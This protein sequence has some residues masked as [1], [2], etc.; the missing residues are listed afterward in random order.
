MTNSNIVKKR[1]EFEGKNIT[2]IN[3]LLHESGRFVGFD[4]FTATYGVKLNFV[5]LYSLKHCLP[6]PW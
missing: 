1:R 4:E 5:D 3:D 2:K 6:R